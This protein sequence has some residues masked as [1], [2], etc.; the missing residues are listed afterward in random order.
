MSRSRPQNGAGQLFDQL[1]DLLVPEAEAVMAAGCLN[2][3]TVAPPT[4][5]PC[6]GLAIGLTS[7]I[8]VKLDAALDDCDGLRTRV[9]R[10]LCKTGVVIGFLGIIG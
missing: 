6:V 10:A 4:C 2:T 3:C 5:L 9:G 1:G 8:V 7:T